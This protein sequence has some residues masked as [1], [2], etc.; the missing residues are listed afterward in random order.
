MV[1]IRRVMG[2]HSALCYLRAQEKMVFGK[3]NLLTHW[4]STSYL[5]SCEE[6]AC[7]KSVNA[8]KFTIAVGTNHCLSVQCNAMS[9]IHN[10]CEHYDVIC[11]ML[12]VGP[13]LYHLPFCLALC[14]DC[15]LSAYCMASLRLPLI[16]QLSKWTTN[17]THFVPIVMTFGFWVPS[18]LSPWLSFRSQHRCLPLFTGALSLQ[19]PV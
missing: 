6:W 10:H 18:L 13:H 2:A 3:L 17:L 8:W 16:A 7:V 4:C 19:Y 9:S 1:Y 15:L 11:I 12:K 14:L 5:Q